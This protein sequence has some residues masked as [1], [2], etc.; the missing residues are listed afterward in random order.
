[1]LHEVLPEK[2]PVLRF[3][4]EKYEPV[5]DKPGYHRHVRN[6][7]KGEFE[8]ALEEYLKYE[9]VSSRN[10]KGYSDCHSVFDWLDYMSIQSELGIVEKRD[11]EIPDFRWIIC[12]FVEGG[13]EG[14]YFHIEAVEPQTHQHIPLILAKTLSGD[15]GLANMIN[16]HINQFIVRAL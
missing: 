14:H 12:W 1:M 2:K 4:F 8:D 9:W 16:M 11:E 5:P 6:C 15:P 3:E 7:T 10:N 13:S